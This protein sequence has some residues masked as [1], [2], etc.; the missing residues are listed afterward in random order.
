MCAVGIS[1]CVALHSG[2]NIAVAQDTR[3]SSGNW[4]EETIALDKASTAARNYAENN[5]GI[6]ILIHLGQDVPN[7]R[8]KNGDELGR[9]FVGR[10]AE[11]GAKAR[12]FYWQNDAPASGVT[13]HIGHLLYEAGGTPLLGLQ[14]AWN[15]APKVIEELKLVKV[16]PR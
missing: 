4:T 3:Y 10:F 6:G 14:T 9:L 16:L 11:L 12:Y 8:V 1:A 13:Y 7:Q 5:Y 15:N 2:G